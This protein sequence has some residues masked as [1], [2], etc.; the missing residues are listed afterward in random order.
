M[1]NI[2]WFGY[3]IRS[4]IQRLGEQNFCCDQKKY[5]VLVFCNIFLNPNYRNKLKM[6]KKDPPSRR[7][8]QMGDWLS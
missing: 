4:K 7:K 6:F 8:T 5:Y 3:H 1:L 2:A